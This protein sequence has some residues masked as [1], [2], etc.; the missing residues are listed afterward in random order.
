MPSVSRTALIL[1][2]RNLGRA[3]A[4]HLAERDWQV[5]GV[6]LSEETNVARAVT[7]RGDRWVP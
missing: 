5:A 4:E 7:S 6:A 2:A 1:G 3:I